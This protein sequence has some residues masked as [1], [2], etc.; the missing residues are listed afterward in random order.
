M[1][2]DYIVLIFVT[3]TFVISERTFGILCPETDQTI[4]TYLS[5]FTKKNLKRKRWGLQ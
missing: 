2:F 5:S 1:A 4:S 3:V